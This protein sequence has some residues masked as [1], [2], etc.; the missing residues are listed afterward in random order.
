MA[1]CVHAGDGLPVSLAILN[2]ILSSWQELGGKK[3]CFHNQGSHRQ[4]VGS[5]GRMPKQ[6]Q[7]AASSGGS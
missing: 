1:G 6:V 2:Y 7:A 3:V 4:S 5:Q